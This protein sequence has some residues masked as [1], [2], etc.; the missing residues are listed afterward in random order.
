MHQIDDGEDFSFQLPYGE[1]IRLFRGNGFAF[2]FPVP[3]EVSQMVIDDLEALLLKPELD[4][5]GGA[6]QGLMIVS[7]IPR[8]ELKMKIDSQLEAVFSQVRT[9]L[10]EQSRVGQ[11][12]RAEGFLPAEVGPF[13]GEYRTLEAVKDGK[14]I[15]GETVYLGG[16][17][18]SVA[19]A[20]MGPVD[21][22]ESAAGRF[23][24]LA[25]RIERVAEPAVIDVPGL[26]EGAKPDGE[27]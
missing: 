7:T 17:K 26:S 20:L 23:R 6:P 21:A 13:R 16:E 14:A 10:A 1:W 8:D 24:E 25:S 9:A 22:F 5:N 3:C 19:W 2:T 15:R 4:G 18:F 27:K 11:D 12:F